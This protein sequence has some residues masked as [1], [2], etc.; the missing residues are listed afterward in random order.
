M[1]CFVSLQVHAAFHPDNGEELCFEYTNVDHGLRYH[2]DTDMAFFPFIN[3]SGHIIIIDTVISN[4][5]YGNTLYS[6]LWRNQKD[7]IMPGERDTIFFKKRRLYSEITGLYDNSFS[8]KFVNSEVVQHLNIFCEIDY[9]YG[10]LVSEDV[11]IP[12][13]FRGGTIF[14]SGQL[15]NGGTDPV[16]VKKPY[17]NGRPGPIEYLDQY[18]KVIMPGSTVELYFNLNSEDLLN[19]YYGS[20]SFETNEGEPRS[21]YSTKINFSGK[22]I[23]YNRP[24]IHFDSLVLHKYVDKHGDGNFEFWFEN[25]GDEPLIIT[26]CKTSCG[27]LVASWPKVPIQPGEREIIKVK[28]DT[29]RVGPINKSIT[30]Q[31]NASSNPIVLRVKG[32]VKNTDPYGTGR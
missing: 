3:C 10:K 1:V 25:D 4:K 23:S 2:K 16:T 11:E 9:N 12:V 32:N 30:V 5:D 22:L 26:T 27:C 24:S 21:Y 29:K 31:T 7:T 15:Y 28:Y 14:F 13:R 8:I 18:P 20:V 17:R 6:H 19:Q